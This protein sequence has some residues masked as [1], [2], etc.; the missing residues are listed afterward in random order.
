MQCSLN[1]VLQVTLNGRP[2]L[3]VSGGVRGTTNTTN[4][5]IPLTSV[6]FYDVASGQWVSL[7]GLEA[8]RHSH[9]MMV[10]EGRLRVV[11]GIMAGQK[12]LRDMETFDGKK[13]VRDRRGLRT[14][15][16]GFSLVKIPAD[17][18]RKMSVKSKRVPRRNKISPLLS[19]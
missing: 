16:K 7:P 6:E 8:G 5:T 3:A 18:F 10:E 14:G 1:S 19:F 13:W 15:R 2:G 9:S 11:G 17:R 12:Y 4:T